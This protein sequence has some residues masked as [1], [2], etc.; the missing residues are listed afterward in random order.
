MVEHH[1]LKCP[2]KYWIAVLK[3]FR[4][5]QCVKKDAYFVMQRQFGSAVL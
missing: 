3:V 4:L 2:V 1:K 5:V